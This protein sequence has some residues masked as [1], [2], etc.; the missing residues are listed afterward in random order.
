MSWAPEGGKEGDGII[1]SYF[2]CH[3]EDVG[4]ENNFHGGMSVPCER[5]QQKLR[6]Y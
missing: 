2:L 5:Q 1:H 3:S 6:E 4:A